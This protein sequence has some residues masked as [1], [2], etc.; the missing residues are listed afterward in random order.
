MNNRFSSKWTKLY[1]LGLVTTFLL[2]CRIFSNPAIAEKKPVVIPVARAASSTTAEGSTLLE[3]WQRAEPDI[4]KWASDAQ[5][6]GRFICQGTAPS[7]EGRCVEWN[8]MEWNGW[9]LIQK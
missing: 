1:L 7:R 2:A 9:L 5:P 6:S 3:A 4:Q 8:G